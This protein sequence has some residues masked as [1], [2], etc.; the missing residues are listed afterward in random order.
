MAVD[1]VERVK[2]HA[3]DFPEA[4]AAAVPNGT[5]T[6]GVEAQ[7]IH[8][9]HLHLKETAVEIPQPPALEAEVV[10]LKAVQM[11]P[12]VNQARGV[13]VPQAQSLVLL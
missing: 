2:H 13:M 1:V 10:L 4:L 9:L 5:V 12:A 6:M 11:E 3:M 7:A 8:R